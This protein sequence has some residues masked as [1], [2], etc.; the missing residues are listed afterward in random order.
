MSGPS[1]MSGPPAGLNLHADQG[2][3]ILGTMIALIVLASTFVVLRLTSRHLARAGFWWDDVLI[4]VALLLAVAPCICIIVAVKHVGFGKHLD[5]FGELGAMEAATGFFHI[6]YFFQLFFTLATGATKLTILAFYRRIFPIAELKFILIVMTTLVVM[7]TTAVSTLIVFQCHPI[8]KFWEPKQPGH[9]ISALND[10]IISG[11]I[12]TI[13][14]F[15]IVCLPVPL[16]WRLR[17]STRQKF[18][19]TGIFL[20]AGFVCIV[21]IIRIISFAKADVADV[22]W[23]FVGVAIWSAVEPIAGIFG[24]CLPS[25]RPLIALLLDN[26]AYRSFAA[27]TSRP[28]QSSASASVLK[29]NQSKS[30]D[31]NSS[32]FARLEEHDCNAKTQRLPWRDQK[33]PRVYDNGADGHTIFVYG[34]R[35][36]P[37]SGEDD[38][39]EMERMSDVEP[40]KGVIRVKTEILLSSSKRFDYN[41]RLY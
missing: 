2:G 21:S 5:A 26:N 35:G 15:T 29:S 4:A 31:R 16:L 17:T 32:T 36:Q 25:L 7:Y 20:T 10:L 22:T 19:L 40:P 9:C 6:L 34:G 23:D 12:N 27:T 41:D 14:D 13:L 37:G 3:K 39:I 18:I 28:F 33:G 38:K 30:K 8:R 1:S 11:S 24:A